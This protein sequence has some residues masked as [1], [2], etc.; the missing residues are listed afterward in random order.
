LLCAPSAQ[1]TIYQKQLDHALPMCDNQYLLHNVTTAIEQYN[2]KNPPANLY[3]KKQQL[4]LLRDFK[5]FSEVSAG[6]FTSNENFDI[7]S[8]LVSLKINNQLTNEDIRV[9][10]S[11]SQG[12]AKNLFLIIYPQD[13]EILIDLVNFNTQEDNFLIKFSTRY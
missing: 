6:G 9:C 3:E 10:K 13:Y 12:P 5:G 1:A 2:Q 8:K 11:T 7:S 4:L